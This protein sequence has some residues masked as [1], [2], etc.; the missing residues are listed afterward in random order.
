M[1]EYPINFT[2]AGY[3]TGRS[4]IGSVFAGITPSVLGEKNIFMYRN[5][6]DT[7]VS[8]YFQVHKKDFR[9]SAYLG[10]YLKL[11]TSRRLPPRN[12]DRFVLDP[13]WGV[14]NICAFNR[15]WSDFLQTRNDTLIITYEEAR[16]NTELV[17]GQIC[18][19]CD[20][21]HEN[22]RDMI[23]A[24]SFE[25]MKAK[26]LTYGRSLELALHGLKRGDPNSMKVRKGIVKGYTE[27]LKPNVIEQAR[28]ICSRYGFA[29]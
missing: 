28:E 26:E 6:L 27:Y 15:A 29:I 9:T 13:T 14:Q 21:S 16:E 7:A 1:L 12:I 19:F 8:L 2:H 5:A 23:K 10:A 24:S 4:E 3:G 25:E 20:I 18:E 22:I 11:L 17:V